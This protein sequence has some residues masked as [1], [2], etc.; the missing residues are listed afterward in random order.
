MRNTTTIYREVETSPDVWEEV[1]VEV[2][3]IATPRVRGA[4]T[5]RNGDP[6]YPDEGGEVEVLS[7]VRTDTGEAVELTDAEVSAIEE[8]VEW[9]DDDGDYEE[10]DYGH[11]DEDYDA[12]PP[13][14]DYGD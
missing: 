5:L 3:Y 9:E 10:D 2:D 6:G 1:E 8:G 11:D 12:D 14:P 4:R 13:E 7:A